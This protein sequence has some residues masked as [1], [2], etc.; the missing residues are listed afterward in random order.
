MAR[1]HFCFFC[2]DLASDLALV[3][4]RAFVVSGAGMVSQK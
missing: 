2:A 3:G 1:A 4:F